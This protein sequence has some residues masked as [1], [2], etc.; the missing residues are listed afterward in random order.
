MASRPHSH[1][2]PGPSLTTWHLPNLH[3]QRPWLLDVTWLIE[4]YKFGAINL[5]Q[6]GAFVDVAV[7]IFLGYILLVIV[8]VL[9]GRLLILVVVDVVEDVV[10][11]AVDVVVDVVAVV[12]VLGL[13]FLGFCWFLVL[14]GRLFCLLLLSPLLRFCIVSVSCLLFL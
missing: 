9:G 4:I 3:V 6:F 10:D 12:V 14:R 13:C 5:Q 7:V 2:H 11:V 8:V 1:R